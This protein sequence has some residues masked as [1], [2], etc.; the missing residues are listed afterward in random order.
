MTRQFGTFQIV[1]LFLTAL[2]L[3]GCGR[4]APDEAAAQGGAPPAL[5]A[6]LSVKPEMVTLVD[7]LPGRVAA[8]RT[9]EIRPQVGGILEKRLFEQGSE[10]EAGQALFQI[11]SDVF[12][13]DVDSAAA[14]L[15]RRLRNP[16]QLRRPPV[17]P[18]APIGV[19]PNGTLAAAG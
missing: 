9:A 8:F 15:Q 11:N 18:P 19:Q 5:V 13:A 7:E 10:V 1:F 4:D 16:D 2:C 17:A 3:A 14:A 12:K 6:V